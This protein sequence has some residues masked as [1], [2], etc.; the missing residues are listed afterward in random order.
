[1][2]A[3]LTSILTTDC[4]SLWASLLNFRNIQRLTLLYMCYWFR[5]H[6]QKCFY[7]ITVILINYM[8]PYQDLRFSWQMN[9]SKHSLL[10]SSFCPRVL[11]LC[12]NKVTLKT[13]KTIA[14]WW[15]NKGV[16]WWHLG[17]NRIPPLIKHAPLAAPLCSLCGSIPHFTG[18][19]TGKDM[20]FKK[21]LSF[22]F[23]LKEGTHASKWEG[24]GGEGGSIPQPWDHDMSQ[25]Q[26]S[27]TQPTEPPRRPKEMVLMAGPE[28][29]SCHHLWFYHPKLKSPP[30]SRGSSTSL[31][32]V[33]PEDPGLPLGRRVLQSQ[34]PSL[35]EDGAGKPCSSI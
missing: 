21:I 8:K 23:N 3:L 19:P 32:H 22:F 24:G 30:N 18:V 17:G 34:L 6:F 12:F 14:F 15:S 2:A 4:Q 10:G 11:S 25:N 9:L 31:A 7:T 35:Q 26:D 16:G 29:L 13:N 5:R 33:F 20:G 27:D 1:M 28:L